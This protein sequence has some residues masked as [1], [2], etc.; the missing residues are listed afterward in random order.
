MWEDS[1]PDILSIQETSELLKI[2]RNQV[3]NLL[4]TGELKG[5]RIGSKTWKIPK[6]SIDAYLWRPKGSN[7]Q[8]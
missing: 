5:F 8:N 4:N 6:E 3:Y 1:Y 7:L 2:G